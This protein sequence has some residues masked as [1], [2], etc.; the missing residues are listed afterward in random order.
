M[1]LV[2]GRNCCISCD[3]CKHFQK[4]M[5]FRAFAVANIDAV[6]HAP[7]QQKTFRMLTIESDL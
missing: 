1:D 2:P 6:Y 7:L 5:S 3:T 4:R